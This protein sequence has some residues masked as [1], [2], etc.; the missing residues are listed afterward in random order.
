MKN[1]TRK[2]IKCTRRFY[3]EKHQEQFE[4]LTGQENISKLFCWPCLFFENEK[5][6]LCNKTVFFNLN[7]LRKEIKESNHIT[8]R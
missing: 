8:N 3:L 6:G 4:W 2:I 1:L 7:N 5:A